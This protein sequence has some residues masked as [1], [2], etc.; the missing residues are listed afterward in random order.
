MDYRKR[1]QT[2]YAQAESEDRKKG[3]GIYYEEHHKIPAHYFANEQHPDG[4]NNPAANL[5]Q[6]KVLL[7]G[8]EHYMSHRLLHK[9]DP[10]PANAFAL[11]MM[12]RIKRNG[13]T[14]TVKGREAAAIKEAASR[15]STKNIL[16]LWATPGFKEDQSRRTTE[17]NY[18]PK[19]NKASSDRMWDRHHNDPQWQK[20]HSEWS[21]KKMTKNHQTPKFI[22]VEMTAVA[23]I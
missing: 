23:A 1:L 7:T 14:Y 11:E 5:P 19:F 4:R 13:K 9:I 22:E 12:R 21:S 15:I 8:K 2:I 18:E 10:C 20:A 3:E 16:K 6:N 17:R